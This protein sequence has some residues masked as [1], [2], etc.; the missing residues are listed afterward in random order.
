[1]ANIMVTELCNLSCPYCFA[2]EFVNKKA[3]EISIDN[4]QKALNFVISSKSFNG[5]IGIIGGEPTTHSRFSEL[6]AI[7]SQIDQIKEALIFTN[8]IRIDKTF[9]LTSSQ[10]FTFLINLNS[11]DVIGYSNYFQIIRNIDVL[12]SKYDKKH[13]ITLGLNIYQ[14]NMDYGFFLNI[15]QKYKF[16][17]ARLSITIPNSDE[18]RVGLDRI[19][20]FKDITYQLYID[21]LYRGINVVFD[22]NKVPLC[23]WTD[24]ELNKISL[25]Q[26]NIENERFGFNLNS[27]KCN[28]IIDILP[29]LTAIRCFGLSQCSKVKLMDFASLD[30]IY[31]YYRINFDEKLVK[32]PTVDACKNCD[33]FKEYSCYSG[34]LTNKLSV[35]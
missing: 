18:E 6:L 29:D 9:N 17:S 35:H 20:S 7:V 25:F 1:M 3:N 21:L 33:K 27:N 16:K 31:N 8:G 34:C 2:N 32:I 5:F 22:C 19:L 15:L 14:Q 12:I 11:P 30:D 4:F 13:S 24:Q 10:K 23:L 28:P 26:A